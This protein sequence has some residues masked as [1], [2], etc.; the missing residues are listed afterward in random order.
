MG[1]QAS[2][3]AQSRGVSTSPASLRPWIEDLPNSTRV[4]VGDL[5]VPF[6]AV[7]VTGEPPVRLYDTSG[8][9][10]HDVRDGLPKRRADSVNRCGR[11]ESNRRGTENEG[12][13][14]GSPHLRSIA[15]S[16]PMHLYAQ[17]APAHCSNMGR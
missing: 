9:L 8:P 10:D 11:S 1:T 7:A 15:G 17:S 6:R 5:A 14:S 13:M 4:E 3:A 2:D 16:R 12:R